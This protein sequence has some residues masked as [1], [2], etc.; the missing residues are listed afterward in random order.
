MGDGRKKT[1]GEEQEGYENR[2]RE[3]EGKETR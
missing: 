3:G 1:M 2:V